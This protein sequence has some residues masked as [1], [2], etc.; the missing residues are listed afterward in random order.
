MNGVYKA[1]L[2][3]TFS[4]IDLTI[5]ACRSKQLSVDN[6]CSDRFQCLLG[7]F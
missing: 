4:F 3:L 2:A 7:C 6:G 1:L 5:N